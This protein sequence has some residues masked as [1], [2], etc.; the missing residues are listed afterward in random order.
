MNEISALTITFYY[1]LLSVT[2]I[3]IC[4][5][6]YRAGRRQDDS[7]DLS[8]STSFPGRTAGS[9]ISWL[10]CRTAGSFMEVFPWRF[11]GPL[12]RLLH[13]W[14]VSCFLV[15]TVLIVFCSLPFTSDTVVCLSSSTSETSPRPTPFIFTPLLFRAE[16]SLTG[17]LACCVPLAPLTGA[18]GQCPCLSLGHN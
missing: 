7:F 8:V 17:D 6:T 12:G 11:D 9:F 3:L 16:S 13:D 4:S 18:L 5:S 10:F 14:K 15:I 1:S 2:V